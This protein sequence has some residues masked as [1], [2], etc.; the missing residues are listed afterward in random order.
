L[1]GQEIIDYGLADEFF[2][3][4]Q[5]LLMAPPRRLRTRA[6]GAEPRRYVPPQGRRR[7]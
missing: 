4:S 6:E 5:P 3:A 7:P 1:F 2:D